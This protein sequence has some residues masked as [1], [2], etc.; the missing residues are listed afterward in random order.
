MGDILPQ[1]LAGWQAE[2]I[3]LN[4]MDD[5]AIEAFATEELF[6]YVKV[7]GGGWPESQRAEYVDQCM[8]Y[9]G[10]V[11]FSVLLPAVQ[12]AQ[13]QVWNPQRFVAWVFDSIEQPRAR[14]ENEGRVL[15]ALTASLEA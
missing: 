3:P 12:A 9:F 1:A 10:E 4:D 15:K 13:R 5:A 2:T 14:L 6:G 11:P 8:K 7:I